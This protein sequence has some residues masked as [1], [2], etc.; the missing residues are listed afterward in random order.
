MAKEGVPLKTQ[1]KS[2]YLRICNSAQTEVGKL[3]TAQ[4]GQWLPSDWFKVK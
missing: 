2:R 3:I 1:K 4:K